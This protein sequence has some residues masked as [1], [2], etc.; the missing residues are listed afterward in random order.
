[1]PMK[2]HVASKV[3]LFQETLEYV[4]AIVKHLLSSTIITTPNVRTKWLDLGHRLCCY[5]NFDFNDVEVCFK[6]N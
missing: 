2:T 6:P 5:K 3:V 4:G 1:M